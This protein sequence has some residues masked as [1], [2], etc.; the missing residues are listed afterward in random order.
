MMSDLKTW[1]SPLNAEHN[2]GVTNDVMFAYMHTKINILLSI[3]SIFFLFFIIFVL[4]TQGFV[5]LEF[6]KYKLG[7][8][9]NMQVFANCNV[10]IAAI[11]VFYI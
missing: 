10:C 6:V 1:C 3:L 9:R 2:P 5:Y 7:L 4:D 11:H 8:H